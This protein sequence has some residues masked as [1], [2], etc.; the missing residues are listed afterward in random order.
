MREKGEAAK[1]AR[2]ERY[3]SPHSVAGGNPRAAV[4]PVRALNRANAAAP[5]AY[6]QTARVDSTSID[7]GG[8]GSRERSASGFIGVPRTRERRG[9]PK[10]VA[11]P[12]G[13]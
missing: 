4:L 11:D 9:V 3:A 1:E 13:K 10:S 2:K 12:A 7:R 6:L 5:R 8:I